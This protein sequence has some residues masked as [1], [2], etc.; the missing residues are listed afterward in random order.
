[1]RGRDFLTAEPR[2]VCEQNYTGELG[3]QTSTKALRADS[4]RHIMPSTS[5]RKAP[6][7]A[8]VDLRLRASGRVTDSPQSRKQIDQRGN[9]GLF[10]RL[11]RHRAVF[12]VSP[13]GLGG[14]VSAASH[15][16][17]AGVGYQEC[18]AISYT[19]LNLVS[20]GGQ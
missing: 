12:V 1:M 15:L 4:K 2:Q 19:G 20:R 10:Q 13:K 14:F 7:K 3:M 17:R 8:G 5:R 18:A 6:M 11:R 16:Q 9:Y